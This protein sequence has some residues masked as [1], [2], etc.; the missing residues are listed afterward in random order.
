MLGTCQHT[1]VLPRMLPPPPGSSAG[2]VIGEE[3]A[4]VG[5]GS[6]KGSDVS[7]RARS[8]HRRATLQTCFSETATSTREPVLNPPPPTGFPAHVS[9]VSGLQLPP[10]STG[11]TNTHGGVLAAGLLTSSTLEKAPRTAF[12]PCCFAKCEE[13]AR[14]HILWLPCALVCLPPQ[15]VTPQ[16]SLVSGREMLPHR[17]D[18][19]VCRLP[20]SCLRGGLPLVTGQEQV[21]G[22]GIPLTVVPTTSTPLQELNTPAAQPHRLQVVFIWS[23]CAWFR[24][25]LVLTQ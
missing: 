16:C 10:L 5:G 15:R 22:P 18:R 6:W 8:P 23:I 12:P 17:Q 1:C 14:G 7:T 24:R 3:G 21:P 25:S 9:Q 11:M 4:A 13:V 19:L 2:A 20:P